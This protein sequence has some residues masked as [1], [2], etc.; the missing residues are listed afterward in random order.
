MNSFLLKEERMRKKKKEEEEE[1]K[2]AEEEG[3]WPETHAPGHRDTTRGVCGV[4]CRAMH[5]VGG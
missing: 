5:Q 1:E 2:E 3:T 4:Y